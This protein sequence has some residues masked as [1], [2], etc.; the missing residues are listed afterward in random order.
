MGGAPGT[1]MRGG[2]TAN[3]A[4]GGEARPM[5][6][7]AGAGY[8]SKKGGGAAFDP[9]NQGRGPAPALAEKAN[10]SPEDMAKEMERQ[11]ADKRERAL[12]KFRERNGKGDQAIVNLDLTYA[13]AFNLAARYHG[14]GLR[15]EALREY[16]AIV[17]NR[18]YPQAGRL[19]ANMGNIFFEQADYLEAV[20]CYRMAL[21]QT[22]N[23]GSEVRSKIFR[24]IGTAFVRMGQYQDA[25]GAYE[26]VMSGSPDVLT[27]LNLLL[28]HYALEDAAQ[29]KR[30][31]QRLV[32]IAIPGLAEDDDEDDGEGKAADDAEAT[33][34]AAVDALRQ[35]LRQ[36]RKEADSYI[37]T[38]AKLI[39]PALDARD[40]DAGYAWVID[41][42]KAERE[43]LASAMEVERALHHLRARQFERAIEGLK[44]FEWKDA[45]LRAMAA[46]NLS[47]IYFLEG[48]FR[49]ADSYADLAV[50]TDRYNAKA[51]V[52]KGNCLFVAREHARAKEVYLEAIGVEVDCVEAI[53]NLGLA[54]IQL[55]LVG[56]ALQAFEKLHTVLPTSAE[57]VYHIA[58][59]HERGRDDL[60]A[61]AKW[62]NILLAR[63]PTDPGVLARMGQIANRQEDESQAYHY[64][65]ESYRHYPA[66]LDVI[67][68]LGVWYVK[69]ELY[70]RAVAFFARASQIQPGEVKWR[71]MVTSCYRRMGAFQRALDLYERIHAE[72]P[73]NLECLRYLVAM[74]K[75]LGRPY[76]QYQAKLA[77]LDRGGGGGGGGSGGG[78][79][80]AAQ[81]SRAA[82]PPLQQ[83]QPQA[84]MQQ[85]Q[86]QDGARG[87]FSGASAA[88]LNAPNVRQL[89]RGAS[90]GG[91]SGAGRQDDDDFA[92]ADVGELLA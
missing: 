69:S 14:A 33:G 16:S 32:A 80:G 56:D 12:C 65:L 8:Q 27:G 58:N 22:P 19:R 68:W 83:Q 7:V 75:D 59:L 47:F 76:E 1:S 82:A 36:K 87:S 13:V 39:A 70:E 84:P 35:E 30:A 45:P 41:A 85:Q 9:L 52:N 3:G 67:S 92:D 6:S 55:G 60:A 46:T 78:G 89:D 43:A 4:G 37:M 44:A 15:K 72:H 73:D 64:H 40:C 63:V 77:R 38:A 90:G 91:G 61:A 53:F 48:D 79:G 25:I 54:N 18:Q 49:S 21:D 24:N 50:R 2:G 81:A 86:Q 74:C 57:V 28:C 5:T 20:K 17:R 34:L 51:L 62:F 26:T 11:E 29:M 10:N 88:G 42:L 23:T 31:F 66:N 71:L